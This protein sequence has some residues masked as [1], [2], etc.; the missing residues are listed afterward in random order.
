MQVHGK[1]DDGERGSTGETPLKYERRAA[2][3]ES[4]VGSYDE[5]PVVETYDGASDPSVTI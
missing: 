5:Q 3:L 1:R 2:N 4:G